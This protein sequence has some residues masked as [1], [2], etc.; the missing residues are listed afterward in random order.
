MMIAVIVHF[1]YIYGADHL[2]A[3][4]FVQRPNWIDLNQK[5]NL[6][7]RKFLRIQNPPK[8]PKTSFASVKKVWKCGLLIHLSL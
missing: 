4:T 8:A 2:E 6:I 7:L 3:A 1:S 5:K